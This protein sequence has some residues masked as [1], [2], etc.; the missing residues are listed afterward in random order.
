MSASGSA[1]TLA[2]PPSLDEDPEALAI[3]RSLRERSGSDLEGPLEPGEAQMV[4]EI[5]IQQA[6]QKLADG[7]TAIPRA[8][9]WGEVEAEAEVEADEIIDEL[10]GGDTPENLE[11]H[12]TRMEGS[13]HA[14]DNEPVVAVAVTR[15]FRA[16][17][18]A[19]RAA[20]P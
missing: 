20:Q 19:M 16:R 15:V 14:Y 6:F 3:L 18:A 10:G 2:P 4:Y 12:A 11:R 8:V 7:A 1:Q 9:D 13:L 5:R 17:A